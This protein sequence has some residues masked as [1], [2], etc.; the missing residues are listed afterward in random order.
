MIIKGQDWARRCEI[1]MARDDVCTGFNQSCTSLL[2]SELIL[3][4]KHGGISVSKL[5]LNLSNPAMM[6][7]HS[8]GTI[9]G[10]Q[11]HSKARAYSSPIRFV[12]RPN[13]P[14]WQSSDVFMALVNL[15]SVYCII[16]RLASIFQLLFSCMVLYAFG[17]ISPKEKKPHLD[18]TSAILD[19]DTLSQGICIYDYYP[20][21]FITNRVLRICTIY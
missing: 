21:R 9:P 3:G 14:P 13:V 8:L 7:E 19:V 12:P 10:H 17:Y 16:Q 1:I 11:I 6:E 15:A 20:L 5:Y 18:S 4:A 2:C